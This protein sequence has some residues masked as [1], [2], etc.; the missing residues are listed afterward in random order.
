MSCKENEAPNVENGSEDSSP[1]KRMAAL[2]EE[3][4]G[5]PDLKKALLEV[6][7]NGSGTCSGG[8]SSSEKNPASSTQL[9]ANELMPPAATQ[10]SVEEVSSSKEVVEESKDV[11][12][13]GSAAVGGAVIDEEEKLYMEKVR[14]IDPACDP[15]CPIMKFLMTKMDEYRD[16]KI[17]QAMQP[18]ELDLVQ[19]AIKNMQHFEL[20][21]DLCHDQHD[22]MPMWRYYMTND[23]IQGLI[24]MNKLKDWDMK[25]IEKF[26]NDEGKENKKRWLDWMPSERAFFVKLELLARFVEEYEEEILSRV[27]AEGAAQTTFTQIL[28]MCVIGGKPTFNDGHRAQCRTLL[29]RCKLSWTLLGYRVMKLL[30][31]MDKKQVF[32]AYHQV[33]WG[34]RN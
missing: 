3:M 31:K 15:R 26:K 9:S 13:E 33:K 20:I 18:N 8:A 11:V 14:R 32:M 29:N 28:Y 10:V 12:K 34:N 1:L 23:R 30:G 16:M 24:E 25:V 21:M 6:V 7:K 2:L 22:F 19:Y 5:Q 27:P 17:E 4:G